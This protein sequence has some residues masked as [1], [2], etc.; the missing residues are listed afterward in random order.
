M[1]KLHTTKTFLT[2]ALHVGERGATRPAC[3][4]PRERN[5][6]TT[7]QQSVSAYMQQLYKSLFS[8]N[9]YLTNAFGNKL[10]NVQS[11]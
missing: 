1:C 7:K 8:L 4:T 10:W 9:F 6:K 5:H 2:L 3:I 11:S